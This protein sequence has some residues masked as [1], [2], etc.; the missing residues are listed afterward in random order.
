[1]L[2]LLSEVSV[3]SLPLPLPWSSDISRVPINLSEA[4]VSSGKIQLAECSWGSSV[5]MEPFRKSAVQRRV[6]GVQ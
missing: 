1:M 3:F 6:A 2:L 5:P 4:G